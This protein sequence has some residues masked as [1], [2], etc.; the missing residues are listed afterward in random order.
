[1]A[2]WPATAHPDIT[3]AQLLAIARRKRSRAPME[4]LDSISVSLERGIDG[5]FRGKPG[6]RQVTVLSQQGW[7]AACDE[8]G[9]SLAWTIR[10][11]NLLI[12]GLSFGP[13]L[14]GQWLWIGEVALQISYECDPC[15]RMDEQAPG[16][17][18][19]LTPDW[20]GGL[21]CRVVRPGVIRVG[22]EVR[23]NAAEQQTPA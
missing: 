13:E 7:Q 22:D 9:H 12:D 23:L 11:A 14:S 17:T 18:A 21:C 8:V 1:M 6:R 5:D 19:A 3:M 20:R 4:T 16:L 2:E 15:P 10:R